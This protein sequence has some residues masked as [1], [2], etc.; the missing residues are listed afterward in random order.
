MRWIAN[1]DL[2]GRSTSARRLYAMAILL[3]ATGIGI[4]YSRHVSAVGTQTDHSDR[5][6]SKAKQTAATNSQAVDILDRY[7]SALSAVNGKA[8]LVI[9]D[10]SGVEIRSLS[11]SLPAFKVFGISDD[12]TQ[13]LYSPLIDG[14][15]SGQL[16]LEDLST[17]NR[18]RVTERLVLS[19]AMSPADPAMIAYTFAGN[20]GFGLGIADLRASSDRVVVEGD[21]FSEFI[22]WGSDGVI[23]YFGTTAAEPRVVLNSPRDGTFTG[24]LGWADED[25]Q[26]DLV[27]AAETERELV[28][29]AKTISPDGQITQEPALTE[30]SGFPRL[31]RDRR[32]PIDLQAGRPTEENANPGTRSFKV[33]SPDGIH[34]LSGDDLVGF[35]DL[36]LDNMASG[37]SQDI[38]KA[39][40]VGVFDSG[41]VVKE[42]LPEGTVTKYVGWDG[43]VTTLG[44]TSVNYRLPLANSTMIQGGASYPAPG[45]CNLT[46]HY[47]TM[48]YAY[49]FQRTT[50]GAHALAIADGLVVFTHSTMAC[51]FIQ[52]SCTD[53][54]PTGCPG[55][56]LGNQVI[57]QHADGTYSAFSHL[58]T[59]SIQV[60]V[61]TSAC[62]GLYVGRQGHTGSVSGPFNNCGDHLHVQRQ[63]SP[64]PSGQS[65]PVTFSDVA[66]HP[67]SCGTG[68]NTSSTEIAHSISAT[69]GSFGVPGG[70]GTV[71]ITSNGC[72]W[73]AV[74][75]DSWITV[76]SPA[77]GSGSGNSVVSFSVS[78][79]SASGPRVGTMVIGGHL[80]TVNQ[81]G[82]GVT[83]SAPVVDAGADQT[84]NIA[85]GVSLVGGITDD[86]LPSP[87]AAV[88]SVWSKVSGGGSV[89]FA[90]ANSPTTTAN[91]SLA[92][93][94]LLRLTANDGA[95]S[96][97][98]DITVIVDVNGAGGTLT[99]GQ[100]TPNTAVN[101]S[102]E[103]TTD[104]AHWGLTDSTSFDHK[105]GIVPQIS[106][107]SRIGSISTIRSSSNGDPT[108]FYSWND[109]TPT[110]SAA[111]TKACV[112]TYGLGN[113]FELTLPADTL[114]RTVR[115]YVGVW[116]VRGRLEAELSDGSASPFVDNSLST[117][118]P[119][120]AMNGVY[121]LTYSAA[122][123]GQTLRLRWRIESTTYPV[124]NINVQAVTLSGATA[125]P[126][127][128]AP[129]VNAGSDQAISLPA[130]VNLTGTAT[131][132]GLPNPPS[133]LTTTWTKVSGPGTVTFGNTNA[134]STTASFS[135]D[136]TYVLRLTGSD[137]LLSA[138]D[139]LTVT[140]N[141]A[142]LP[143]SLSGSNALSPTN[144]NLSSGSPTDWAHWGLN[145]ANS[146][147]HK[148]GVT[149]QIS[150]FTKIG[151]G[152]TQQYGNNP[153]LFSWTGG[154]PS[155]SATNTSTGIYVIG[156]NNG[157]QVTVPA[158][159]TARTLK[160]YVGLWAAG[161]RFEASLSDGSAP[162][163]VDTSISNSA[164]TSNGVYTLNYQA[165]SPGQTLTVKWFVNTTFNQWSNVTLQGATL[166]TSGPP[167]NQ[168]PVVNAGSDQSVSLPS[169]ANVSG[170]ATDDGLPNPPSVMTTSWTKVSGPGT[171]TFGN[172]NALSTTASFS[173]DGTYV[174]RLTG[175]DSVLSGSDDLTVTVNPAGLPGSLSGSN[176][177]SPTNVNLSSGSPTDWAHWGLSGA[178][179]FNHKSGVTQQISNFTKI[180]SGSTQQY[181]NNPTFYSWTGGTPTSSATNTS[182][183]IYVIG[184]NNGFQVTVPADTT[185]RTLKMYVGL[186]AA[187]GRFEAS[188]SDGSAPMYVD[189]SISNSAGTSNGVYTLNYQA[190]SPGQTLTVKW[191]VNAIFNQWS[192]VTLQGA[193]LF[194]GT[195]PFTDYEGGMEVP[196]DG[197]LSSF[198]DPDGGLRITSRPSFLGD[199]EL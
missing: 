129:V 62:Q 47:D 41:L 43:K 109:G 154:T 60:E 177:V 54:S 126:V 74:S 95:L 67:L 136:G 81:A 65:V 88:T 53:Y 97:S 137:S 70:N 159:T 44:V 198:L 169:S 21:V 12:R 61:G 89:T 142:G 197:N 96:S 66:S 146:F 26:I 6:A 184:M 168:P 181:G 176:A 128:Q 158:D 171:V 185:A 161:G 119:A 189:T 123:A 29:T 103:G 145:G 57:I 150:N 1:L 98:D 49:D 83:N 25:G 106:D 92:G 56:Y 120:G 69:S 166:A 122:S 22:R 75:N 76:T 20:G 115:L 173:I 15:P 132:D 46:A 194:N 5:R 71:N 18:I 8:M 14:R 170:T 32:A 24:R 135:I 187:G 52:P 77:G 23:H 199:R 164:G 37:A 4:A 140:V 104:W 91:F 90:N 80:Y 82:G 165:G 107:L 50:V 17:Q 101:L 152:S 48:G 16:Y 39:V 31:D 125:P 186:W 111:S 116:R 110:G 100:T 190:G 42:F 196:L 64:D 73:N 87:P 7:Q 105:T 167:V 40:L 10:G 113:G 28:L 99:G 163:Y 2:F 191:F 108:V 139:D 138:S 84:V 130:S 72:T 151:S 134:L 78:D 33:Y 131:D 13:L 19:A 180:G 183:G 118:Y 172:A 51:N 38:G 174:L 156:M 157:F 149:Q 34:R 93:I 141:P 182:T 127:N 195:I 35:N 59:D 27:R 121:T 114:Q 178:N 117:V 85:A 144:V 36:T 124:G 63:V 155:S 58:Q 3:I 188:L 94:Y 112:Y 162:T 143:G 45:A 133:A 160:M 153:T 148:S 179:S 147:N 192:N 175:S 9:D 55:F 102:S 68:Y 86:G 79:N 193:T 11:T 30:A